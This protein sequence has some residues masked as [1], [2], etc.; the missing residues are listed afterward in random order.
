MVKFDVCTAVVL[1]QLA[2]PL[3][4]VRTFPALKA[5]GVSKLS[6]NGCGITAILPGQ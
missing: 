3:L 2:T 4:N 5:M 6:I 1:E